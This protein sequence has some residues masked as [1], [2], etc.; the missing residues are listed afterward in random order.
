LEILA[1]VLVGY[2]QY[3]PQNGKTNS[4]GSAPAEVGAVKAFPK[5]PSTA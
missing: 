1:K 2:K 4:G 5:S 3:W